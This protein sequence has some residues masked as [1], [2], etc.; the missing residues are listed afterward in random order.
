MCSGSSSHCSCTGSFRCKCCN[1]V[2]G[3]VVVFGC[4]GY[5]CVAIC[6]NVPLC[7][8]GTKETGPKH[9]IMLQFW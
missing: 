1:S 5:Y 4:C 2:G 8:K 3:V 6:N 7:P 9:T